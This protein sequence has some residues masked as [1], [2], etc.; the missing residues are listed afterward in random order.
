MGVG[1]WDHGC[2]PAPTPAPVSAQAS[3]LAPPLP[4]CRPSKPL[5]FSSLGFFLCGLRPPGGAGGLHEEVGITEPVGDGKG[6]AGPSMGGGRRWNAADR[7][8]HRWVW[9]ESQ[10]GAEGGTGVGEQGSRE[11]GDKARHP[12]GDRVR[13]GEPAGA[14]GRAGQGVAAFHARTPHPLTQWPLPPVLVATGAGSHQCQV[15]ACQSSPP[16]TQIQLEFCAVPSELSLPA[17]LILV[18]EHALSA[19]LPPGLCLGCLPL[20]GGLPRPHRLHTASSSPP[21][22][23]G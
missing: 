21:E 9:Q 12:Q 20:S 17:P 10:P 6:S 8:S 7:P 14:T 18:S 15:Q 2:P 23:R 4:G 13:L 22:N 16:R 3:A 1:L 5:P 19:P 11:R